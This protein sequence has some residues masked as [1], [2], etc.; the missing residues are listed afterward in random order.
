MNNYNTRF[1]FV[2]LHY[3]TI[4]LTNQC[5]ESIKTCFSKYNYKII[6]V[7][8]FS[9]DSSS[10]YL[11]QNYSEKEEFILI[12]NSS[13]LGFAKANNL[14]YSYA[15]K[16]LNPDF[17]LI[18]N[19]DTVFENQ[20]FLEEVVSCYGKTGFMVMGPDI[21]SP[22]TKLHQSPFRCDGYEK[23]DLLNLMDINLI[24][25]NSKTTIFKEWFRYYKQA[26]AK[27]I[28]KTKL[29]DCI[30]SKYKSHECTSFELEVKDSIENGNYI[31]NPVLHGACLIY[32]KE[33]IINEEYAFNN[34]TFLYHEEDLL[35][36]Y[37]KRK[38]YLMVFDPK[39]RI[40]HLEGASTGFSKKKKGFICYYKKKKFKISEMLKSEKIMLNL[41]DE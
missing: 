3:K 8:N 12:T 29:Y 36:L 30:L 34:S 37:C 19:S 28:K 13:N 24:F 31:F 26:L 21:V 7:D 40:L 6:I 2:I 20:D 39:A 18:I 32:S 38:S 4:E 15:K 41:F 25:L 16:N 1:V 10:A 33:F 35:H 5:I 14:G 11:K 23:N 22:Y 9:N 27:I 17:I